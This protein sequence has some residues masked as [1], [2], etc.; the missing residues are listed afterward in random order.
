MRQPGGENQATRLR[1]AEHEV[2]VLIVRRRS[3]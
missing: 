3:I 1:K 2:T